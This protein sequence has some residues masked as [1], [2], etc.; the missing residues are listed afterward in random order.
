MLALALIPAVSVRYCSKL[1]SP[2]AHG[3]TLASACRTG[4]QPVQVVGQA[5]SLSNTVSRM[6]FSVQHSLGT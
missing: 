2:A 6:A 3:H 1:W 4:C 5:A